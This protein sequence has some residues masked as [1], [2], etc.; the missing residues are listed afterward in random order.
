[1]LARAHAIL[2]R[3]GNRVQLTIYEGTV[4]WLG[5]VSDKEYL[6]APATK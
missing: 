4:N 6:A 5:P 1:L 2:R 3:G